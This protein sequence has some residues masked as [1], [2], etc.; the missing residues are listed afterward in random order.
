MSATI[1]LTGETV[2]MT[3]WG[4]HQK[5]FVQ[6]GVATTDLEMGILIRLC[7]EGKSPRSSRCSILGFGLSTRFTHLL[8]SDT[9]Y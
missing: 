7:E 6:P 9:H 1:L 2:S 8:A 4:H 3:V 5:M